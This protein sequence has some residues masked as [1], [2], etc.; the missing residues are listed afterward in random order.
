MGRRVVVL[1]VGLAALGA[2]AIGTGERAPRSTGMGRLT[3]VDIGP[4]GL[5]QVEGTVQSVD[6]NEGI[7]VI[8]RPSGLLRLELGKDTPIYVE[9]GVAALRDVEEGWPVRASFT[10][11]NGE[12]I[13]HW[14]E[15]P[16]PEE[17]PE[18]PNPVEAPPP[19][20]SAPPGGRAP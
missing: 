2:C 9:G 16:R 20:L 11:E 19:D 7:L 18:G 15:I 1:A 10:V 17:R 12:R 5:E 6:A 13:A 3:V 14:V 4:L 8:L